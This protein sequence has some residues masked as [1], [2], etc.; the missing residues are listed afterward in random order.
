MSLVGKHSRNRGEPRAGNGIAGATARV[1][2]KEVG[3]NKGW[4]LAAVLAMAMPACWA[5]AGE[6][7]LKAPIALHMAVNG[8]VTAVVLTA[9][10]I[11]FLI[12]GSLL[13]CSAAVALR[14]RK[15]KR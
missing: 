6:D 14:A 8:A 4:I 3:V 1:G 15:G 12:V 11:A 13:A 5:H 2:S 9:G 7:K 10:Y